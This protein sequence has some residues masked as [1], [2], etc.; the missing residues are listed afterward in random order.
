MILY[1]DNY[2]Y[3]HSSEDVWDYFHYDFKYYE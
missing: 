3:V 2:D 1:Y